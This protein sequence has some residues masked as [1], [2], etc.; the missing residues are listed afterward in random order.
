VHIAPFSA[1]L[2]ALMLMFQLMSARDAVSD[3]FFRALYA[4]LLTPGPVAS[5]SRS[6]MFLSLLFKAMKA[7]VS[8]KRCAAFAKR[9][10]QVGRRGRGL[11]GLAVL[12]RW[13]VQQLAAPRLEQGSG[14]T[15]SQ[16]RAL[17]PLWPCRLRLARRPPGPPARCWC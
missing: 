11:E 5:G 4:V 1:G 14:A 8:A 3:R 2:Q 6:S 12:R 16:L 9:L 7:D 13:P 15:G 10:L 17:P